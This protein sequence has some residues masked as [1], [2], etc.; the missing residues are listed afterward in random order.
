MNGNH[1]P[2]QLHGNTPG[3]QFNGSLAAMQGDYSYVID[4]QEGNRLVAIHHTPLGNDK[5]ILTDMPILSVQ[6][7]GESI[8]AQSQ[9][10]PTQVLELDIVTGQCKRT[11]SIGGYGFSVY[12]YRLVYTDAAEHAQ[13]ISFNLGNSSMIWLADDVRDFVLY[14]S[15][16]YYVNQA[17]HDCL[18]RISL[19][20]TGCTKLTNRAVERFCLI[21]DTIYY[22]SNGALYT[23]DDPDHPIIESGVGA[24]NFVS[25]GSSLLYANLNDG[26][27]TYHYQ[28][29]TNSSWLFST[30]APDAITITSYGVYLRS[31]DTIYFS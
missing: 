24:F 5:T 11:L 26:G 8:Y 22:T 20:G 10:D 19:S 25:D 23:I 14:N 28:L 18:Y 27:K 4:S 12:Q 3:N 7:A 9:N 21:N 15:T 2:Y 6:V 16:A 13:L 1:Q 17:D 29:S 30:V 31:G